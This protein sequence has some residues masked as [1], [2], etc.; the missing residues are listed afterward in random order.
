[1][2]VV[3]SYWQANRKTDLYALARLV[4]REDLFIK[5]LSSAHFVTAALHTLQSVDF[6]DGCSFKIHISPVKY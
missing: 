3:L 5:L 6:V 4:L 1:M 2:C